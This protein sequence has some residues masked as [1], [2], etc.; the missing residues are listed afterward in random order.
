MP[1]GQLSRPKPSTT[2]TRMRQVCIK[3]VSPSSPAIS[4]KA[5]RIMIRVPAARPLKP[6]MMLM[7][8]ATPPT[9]KAVNATDSTVKPSSQSRPGTL[10]SVMDWPVMTQPSS[11]EA[12]VASSL[13]EIETRLVRSSARPKP[14]AGT[15]AI[16]KGP[17]M[18]C[19][20]GAAKAQA[21]TAPTTTATP[22]MRGVACV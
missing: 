16:S 21:T 20:D 10:T 4:A 7:A 17:R 15:P 22:P 1:S 13:L 18:A 19:T 5:L 2:V 14:K 12:M 6:S 8:L 11:P 3:S 9:A